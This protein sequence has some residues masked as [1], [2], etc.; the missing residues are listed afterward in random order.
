MLVSTF[1]PLHL[2]AF[3]LKLDCIGTASTCSNATASED[4][5][6]ELQLRGDLRKLL[7]KTFARNTAR[8]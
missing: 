5:K 2:C 7:P 4:N 6:L 8:Q 1:A 3:A